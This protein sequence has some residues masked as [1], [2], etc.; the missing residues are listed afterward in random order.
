MSARI[1]GRRPYALSTCGGRGRGRGGI[2][3][4][5]PSSLLRKAAEQRGLTS[6][7]QPAGRIPLSSHVG[8]L[9][10]LEEKA[11]QLSE[12]KAQQLSEQRTCRS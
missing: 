12:E 6:Y 9:F 1:S 3:P 10:S 2:E 5:S 7:T 8:I 11:Q 4:P